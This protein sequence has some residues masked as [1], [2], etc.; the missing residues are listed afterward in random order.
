MLER[1]ECLGDHLE[2]AGKKRV[3]RLQDKFKLD[4]GVTSV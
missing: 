1:S 2:E 3:G 4:F